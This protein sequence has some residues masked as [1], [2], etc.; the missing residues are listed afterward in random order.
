MAKAAQTIY[1]KYHKRTDTYKVDKLV[2]RMIPTIGDAL[3]PDDVADLISESNK[4]GSTLT[5]KV[6]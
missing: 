6:S 4:I 5:V 3:S 2:N 1:L